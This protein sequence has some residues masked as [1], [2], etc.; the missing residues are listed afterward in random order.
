MYLT[1]NTKTRKLAPNSGTVSLN[2]G[3]FQVKVTNQG[4]RL[5]PMGGDNTHQYVYSDD[6]GNASYATTAYLPDAIRASTFWIWQ[7]TGSN[8]A[9]VAIANAKLGKQLKTGNSSG[10]WCKFNT[11]KDSTNTNYQIYR[12]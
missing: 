4:L 5:K 2:R 10:S 9:Y 6:D 8:S 3:K 7:K 11:T 12:H 1:F